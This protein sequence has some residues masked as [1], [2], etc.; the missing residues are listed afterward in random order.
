VKAVI[1]ANAM[2]KIGFKNVFF[3]FFLFIFDYFS[4]KL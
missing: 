2:T 1:I 3:I 4:Q